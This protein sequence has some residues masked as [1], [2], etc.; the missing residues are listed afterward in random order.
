MEK[1]QGRQEGIRKKEQMVLHVT[2]S[3]TTTLTAGLYAERIGL[4]S[5]LIDH[6]RNQKCLE[7]F[8]LAALEPQ[9]GNAYRLK[10]E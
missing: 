4:Y 1:S 8:W 6:F 9:G 2:C 10:R 7:L 5:M 3:Q